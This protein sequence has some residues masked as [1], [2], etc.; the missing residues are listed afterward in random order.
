MLIEGRLDAALA[1]PELIDGGGVRTLHS[2]V[3]LTLN[4]VVLLG[5][6]PEALANLKVLEEALQEV[7]SGGRESISNRFRPIVVAGGP[8]D[9]YVRNTLKF[10]TS[11]DLVDSSPDGILEPPTVEQQG[12]EFPWRLANRMV[13][14]HSAKIAKDAEEWP[15]PFVLA[16]ELE[17]IEVVRLLYSEFPL[18]AK[19]ARLVFP[20]ATL[21]SSKSL[22][23][24]QLP[25][26]LIGL[27]S[28]EESRDSSQNQAVTFVERSLRILL[29]SE[30]ELCSDY[31]FKLYKALVVRV[32]EFL[33]G[34][35]SE[36]PDGF[37]Y[38]KGI[39]KEP[40]AEDSQWAHACA[41]QFA[42]YCLRLNREE[43]IWAVEELNLPWK[44]I[45]ANVRERA[46]DIPEGTE[47][48]SEGKFR[49]GFRVFEPFCRDPRI[50]VSGSVGNKTEG[51]TILSIPTSAT[52][53]IDLRN[54]GF[55]GKM[56]RHFQHLA[57][58][59][60]ITP[61]NESSEWLDARAALDDIRVGW[62]ETY[63][64]SR[65]WRFFRSNC[66]LQLNAVIYTKGLNDEGIR[67]LEDSVEFGL[68]GKHRA[69]PL[70]G[71][72]RQVRGV[73]LKG[74]SGSEYLRYEMGLRTDMLEPI[75]E[76]DARKYTA[77]LHERKADFAL[78][79]LMHCFEILDELKGD[80]RLLFPIA[81]IGNVPNGANPLPEYNLGIGINRD[82]PRWI[83]YAQYAAAR[84]TTDK[85]DY[86]RQIVAE[87]RD[88]LIEN[89]FE[90]WI[91]N[92]SKF[93]ALETLLRLPTGTSADP[94]SMAECIVVH[95]LCLSTDR[96]EAP[97]LW[98]KNVLREIVAEKSTGSQEKR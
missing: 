31:L 94:R 49:L 6:G 85:K 83:E 97:G 71:H 5:S 22:P 53:V 54:M 59:A 60:M 29:L 7:G 79:D 56:M 74:G 81:G 55:L 80:G 51:S 41:I 52:G 12:R 95:M 92:L 8:G 62:F 70:N 88:E 17:A 40:C 37:E 65:Q 67:D 76:L 87:L 39:Q 73:V 42:R 3:R 46:K 90:P 34:Y 19:M 96:M 91:T 50:V 66:F 82:A 93:G 4:A 64:K 13:E 16:D 45:L 35:K 24:R 18:V 69:E 23:K 32:K 14:M 75:L 1:I 43:E 89:H 10:G 36:C 11:V 21:R 72:L 84:L 86:L 98:W 38:L 20:L 63:E 78:V 57:D 27:A 68:T 58:P 33:E 25:I 2:P 15:I 48:L 9:H 47:P 26:H 28:L 77:K 44:H 30:V 61:R